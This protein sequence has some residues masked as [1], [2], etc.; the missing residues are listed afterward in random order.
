LSLS[1]KKINPRYAFRFSPQEVQ[2]PY[3]S[4]E[5]AFQAGDFLLAA[6]MATPETETHGCALLM[7]GL[8]EQGVSILS[9]QER[10][11][12]L[13]QICRAYGAWLLERDSDALAILDS[14]PA[15]T[16]EAK[17]AGKLRELIAADEI[18]IF[19]TATMLPVVTTYEKSALDPIAHYGRFVVKHVA[20]PLPQNAYDL[21]ERD[22]SL[23]ELIEALP[24][25][26]KPKLIFALTPQWVVPHGLER[27]SVPKV[28]WCHDSDHFLYEAFDN[29]QL[30]D[31][32]IVNNSQEHFELTQALG[33]GCASNIMLS[34]LCSPFPESR[35]SAAKDIDVFVSGATLSSIHSDKG[36]FVYQLSELTKKKD[37]AV[38]VVDGHMAE[39]D[40]FSLLARSKFS[41]VVNRY[42]GCPSP[43]WRD[44][45]SVSTCLLYP[46][47]SLYGQMSTAAYPYRADFIAEDFD[48][49]LDAHARAGAQGY[50]DRFNSTWSNFGIYR[51]SRAKNFE[52][53]LKFAAFTALV[54][55]EDSNRRRPEDVR[56]RAVWLTPH[57]DSYMFGEDNVRSKVEKYARNTEAELSANS[58]DKDYSNAAKLYVQ[59]ARSAPTE[60]QAKAWR[61]MADAIVKR[62]LTNHPRSLLLRFN[63]VYWIFWE[64][65]SAPKV[66]SE[67]FESLIA[68]FDDLD[69]DP[70][71]SDVGL[72]LI[73]SGADPVF[74][75]VQY[76][77]EIVSLATLRAK[78]S[79]DS[80]ARTQMSPR[81][82]LLSLCHA[83]LGLAH[84]QQEKPGEAL[85]WFKAALVIY[86]DNE[87][88]LKTTLGALLATLNRKSTITPS[89]AGELSDIFLRCV[90]ASPSF[91]M[92]DTSKVIPILHRARRRSECTQALEKWFQLGKIMYFPDGDS[93]IGAQVEMIKELLAFEQYFPEELR[94][95][96]SGL[97]IKAAPG[98]E[99]LSHFDELLY[100][101]MGGKG[102]RIPYYLKQLHQA[103]QRRVRRYIPPF[104]HR[105]LRARWRFVSTRIVEKTSP[106]LACPL[107]ERRFR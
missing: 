77:R 38:V 58:D 52:L 95:R 21:N 98:A 97:R 10:L 53:L 18:T 85:V 61:A 3:A 60:K 20:S 59:L 55:P 76:G 9:R 90:N 81:K 40:Y 63:Q 89:E 14:L 70:F 49:H 46:E 72:G 50:T 94:V 31:L 93:R 67:M 64:T 57:I 78:C 4:A 37:L 92:T 39:E 5:E 103:Y 15:G 106:V 13:G 105:W 56:R 43:R 12:S 36:K 86:P 96:M 28:L 23:D 71:G 47:G 73:M 24:P 7:G 16:D 2:Q 32:T 30:Y 107:R 74:P 8:V 54:W 6:Q 104:F 102:S 19:V 33:I 87:P 62:G 84:L 48:R 75:Y 80:V 29:F 69:F 82:L 26:E 35:P 44:T 101:A 11:T 83:Y 1:D 66:A 25:A 91:L 17:R 22:Q 42:L 88:L 68:D 45:L 41:P 79:V 34:P 27:V 51:Q 65:F 100:L 99:R